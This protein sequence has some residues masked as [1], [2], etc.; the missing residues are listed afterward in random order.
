MPPSFGGFFYLWMEKAPNEEEEK[1][2]LRV[3]KVKLVEK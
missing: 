3:L 1:D 2:F